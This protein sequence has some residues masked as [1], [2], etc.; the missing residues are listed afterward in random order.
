MF[1]DAPAYGNDN[2]ACLTY[3][4]GPSNPKCVAMRGADVIVVALASRGRPP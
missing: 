1:L 2:H 4:V 3:C